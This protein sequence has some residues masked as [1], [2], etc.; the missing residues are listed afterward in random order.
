MGYGIPLTSASRVETLGVSTGSGT[1]ISSS[2]TAGVYSSLTTVGTTTFAYDGFWLQTQTFNQRYWKISLSAAT[3]GG[4][5][6]TIVQDA[7]FSN[8]SGNG[9]NLLWFPIRV[10]G[11]ATL[12]VQAAANFGSSS[13]FATIIGYQGNQNLVKGFS[14]AVSLTD[15]AANSVFPANTIT[16]SGTTLTGWSQLAASTAQPIEAIA[17]C[18]N[19][20]GSAFGSNIRAAVELGYGAAGSEVSAGIQVTT[21]LLSSAGNDPIVL[22]C[23][24]PAATRLAMRA[25]ASAAETHACAI[26]AWG[27]QR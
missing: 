1:Q 21:N 2:G 22:P 13:F 23:F 6:Q 26:S 9:C 7:F 25:Q 12:K 15:F 5:D 20:C 3:G 16:L 8:A 10:A 17:L 19:G 24:I 14:R 18:F 11:D 4:A 27:F